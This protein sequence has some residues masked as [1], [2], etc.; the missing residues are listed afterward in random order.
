[1]PLKLIPPGQRKGNKYFV[2][3]GT[4]D[5]REYECSTGTTDH[6]AADERMAELRLAILQGNVATSRKTATFGDAADLYI[7]AKNPSANE[8]RYIKKLRTELEA[9]P[10]RDVRQNH[11]EAAANVLYPAATNQTKNR[12]AFVPAAAILHY[13]ADADLC[14]WVRLRKLPE[15]KPRSQ[16]STVEQMAKLIRATEGYEHLLLVTLFRQ[17]WRITETLGWEWDKIDLLYTRTEFYIRKSKSWKT[18]ELHPDTVEALCLVPIAKRTGKVFPWA[19]RE[20]V[21]RWLKPLCEKQKV[22]F[23]PH[24]AR[25]AFGSDLANGGYASRSIME[26]GSWTSEKSVQ[27]YV[28]ID[29]EHVRAALK[30][31][32]KMPKKRGRTRGKAAK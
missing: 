16:R 25:H 32:P 12:Q 11:V 1:M 10:V 22:V 31:L 8:R 9:V 21:Y 23:T 7:N 6:R 15:G 24:M 27:R 5:G 20:R 2:I 26:A 14:G 13:A 19:R 4:V 30:S 3:R 17:G 18:I 28:E 29:R